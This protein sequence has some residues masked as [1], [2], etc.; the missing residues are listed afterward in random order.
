MSNSNIGLKQSKKKWLLDNYPNEID[1][2]DFKS[3]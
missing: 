3:I 1:L 2:S